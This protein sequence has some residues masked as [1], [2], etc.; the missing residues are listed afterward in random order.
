MVDHSITYSLNYLAD[1]S[2][3]IPN[4]VVELSFLV[5]SG[6]IVLVFAFAKNL[7]QAKKGVMS[8]LLVEYMFLILCSTVFYRAVAEKM[9]YEFTPFWSYMAIAA[10]RSELI[11]DDLMNIA[12]GIPVGFL[13]SFIMLKRSW[14]KAAVV[15]FLFSSVIELSQLV[16]RRGLC[17][18]DDIF[19][20]TLGAV[21]G[22]GLG[23]FMV[24]AIR[25]LWRYD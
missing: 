9:N 21:V 23:L 11:E 7:I 6:V 18:L 1:V 25:K 19:H 3:E 22:Y 4:M 2:R 14:W 5:M 15:G 24:L 13:L 20:N 12:L 10:G 17:E 16:F 8:T